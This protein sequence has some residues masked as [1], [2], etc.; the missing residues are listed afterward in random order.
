MRRGQRVEHRQVE[1]TFSQ[2]LH[3]LIIVTI[4]D[5]KVFVFILRARTDVM[6]WQA[7]WQGRRGG[8]GAAAAATYLCI[9]PATCTGSVSEIES[10]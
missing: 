3:L 10:I 4:S 8:K 9:G 7:R 6:V 2:L 5:G 1:P